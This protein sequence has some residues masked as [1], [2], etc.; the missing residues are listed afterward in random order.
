VAHERAGEENRRSIMTNVRV[1]FAP[2][3]TGHLHVGGARTALFNWLFARHEGGV[4]ILRIEDTDLERSERR[5]EDELLEDL[6][7]LGL[8]WDE[9]PG[10]GGS[11][12][13]YR[14]SERVDTYREG[15][16][17]LLASG[18][19]YPCFC[20]DEE[21]R[22]KREASI[23]AGQPP[24]Y[25]GTCRSLGPADRERARAAGR[26]E[27]VRFLVPDHAELRLADIVRGEVVFRA[28]MVGDFVIL[29]SNGL[30]VY[31]FAA[32]VD[33]A[34]MGITHVIR[35]EEHLSNTLRQILLYEALGHP[36]PRFAHLPLILAQ[37]RSK[38]SK[39][40]GAP[41]VADFRE[42]GYPAE[43]IINYLAFLGWS[44]PSGGEILPVEELERDFTLERVSPSPG[45]FDESK[46]NWVAASHIRRGG[47]KRY[48]ENASA[49]FPEA[50]R[51]AYPAERLRE[52]FDI[53]S[54]NLPCFS[55]IGDE[56]APWMPGIPEISGE[57]LDAVRDAAPLLAAG[58]EILEALDEWRAPRIAEALKALGR[59]TGRKGKP[60]YLPLRAAVTGALHGPDLSRV[61]EIRG[62]DDVIA[63]LRHGAA[64]A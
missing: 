21:L 2:S 18:A 26:P 30:P 33:D 20:T 63:C 23:A 14:Q 4:F 22:R 7:W 64:R 55:R 13:P 29:R 38:L 61:M 25:D 8:A 49:Y 17:A 35:G 51:A 6:A 41:N 44:P 46:L 1:R 36:L 11:F 58:V 57:A 50:M 37:D 59:R 52:I 45:I 9:G 15:A 53:I 48:F 3:P 60:L 31:N 24:Q 40:H 62:R 28:G 39:R 34:L 5:L 19:A 32:V 56:A 42:R 12:G 43:A 16:E 27:S 10:R 47:S 54:E